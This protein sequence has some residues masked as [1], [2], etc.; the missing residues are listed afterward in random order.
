MVPSSNH[1]K[2]S[3]EKFKTVKTISAKEFVIQECANL[4]SVILPEFYIVL[5][6]TIQLKSCWAKSASYVLTQYPH[7]RLF[8][9]DSFLVE[10]IS[11]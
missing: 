5:Q 9:K 2:R 1:A 7:V 3:A 6:A 11:V 4:A 10:S 8:A